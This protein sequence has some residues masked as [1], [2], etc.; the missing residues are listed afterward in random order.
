MSAQR[1]IGGMRSATPRPL[2]D[3]SA[4]EEAFRRSAIINAALL[5]LSIFDL[6]E[7]DASA[8]RARI[9]TAIAALESARSANN[10]RMVEQQLADDTH[11]H[12]RLQTET[13]RAR[14][15]EFSH[16]IEVL[17][18]AVVSFRTTNTEFTDEVLD[19]S[20]RMGKLAAIDDLR[21]L[22]AR[23]TQEVTDLQDAA[24]RKQEADARQMAAL[25]SQVE[26]LET[27]LAVA[28]AQAHH[29]PLTGL[30]NRAG[31]DQALS[32]VD[33]HLDNGDYAYAVAIIDLDNFKGIN[34]TF[35]HTAGDQVLTQCAELCRAAFD[36]DDVVAR[37]GGDEFAVLIAAPTAEHAREH[38]QALLDRVQGYNRVARN[39]GLVPFSLSIGLALA[40]EGDTVAGLVSRAD[41]ALYTAKDAGRGRM[42]LG[43]A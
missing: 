9:D 7:A 33:T 39:A 34:D 22:R 2:T 27:R 32:R 42:V 19:R 24:V 36:D 6:Q 37:I 29:D 43:A 18:D 23:L 38:V 35:G 15:E 1:V 40:R 20:E 25:S 3:A 17:T 28:V 11:R 30:A 10:V 41:K 13:L 8:F 26:A 12:L 16:T 4:L 5:K 21:M 14:E 31:W